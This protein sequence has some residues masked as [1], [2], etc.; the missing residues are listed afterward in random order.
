M[1]YDIPNDRP[2]LFDAYAAEIESKLEPL[3]K[4]G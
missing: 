4:R 3:N 2:E 1:K